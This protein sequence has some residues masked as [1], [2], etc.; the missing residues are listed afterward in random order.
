GFLVDWLESVF[1]AEWLVPAADWLIRP[2]IP[3]RAFQQFLA[4]PPG[5]AVEESNGLLIGRYG[6]LSMAL[7]YG[8]ASVLPIVTTFFIAF[9]IMEDS[10]YLPRRAVVANKAMK[11]MGLNGKAVLP[12]VLGLGCDTMATMT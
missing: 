7:S 5:V 9:S 8:I 10:G 11:G 3:A 12:M 4:G 2:L 1:F 6:L